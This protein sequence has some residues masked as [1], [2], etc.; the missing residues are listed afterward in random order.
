M[1]YSTDDC[2]NFLIQLY[3]T[4]N[5]KNWRRTR[6]YTNEQ[7]QVARDF[8]CEHIHQTIVE[9]PLGLQA[10][11]Q[12]V[13][14]LLALPNNYEDYLNQEDAEM[15]LFGDNPN[16]NTHLTNDYEKFKHV[17]R[18]G[19]DWN[20]PEGSRSAFDYAKNVDFKSV[21]LQDKAVLDYTVLYTSGMLSFY[22]DLDETYSPHHCS[23]DNFHDSVPDLMNILI[24]IKEAYT[25][26]SMPFIVHKAYVDSCFKTIDDLKYIMSEEPAIIKK[27]N[28]ELNKLKKFLLS[29]QAV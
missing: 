2:K 7:G 9:T 4:T 16:T 28:S 23:T 14:K 13:P 18:Y 5:K 12:P 15:T 6:K 20:L 1:S 11:T 10:Y 17:L 3:P 22:L 29:L 24:R 8:I 26:H 27:A 25:A 21:V 19:I